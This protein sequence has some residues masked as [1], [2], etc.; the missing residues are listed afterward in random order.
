MKYSPNILFISHGIYLFTP[1]H[2]VI[3]LSQCLEVVNECRFG[4]IISPKRHSLLSPL[5]FD[6][7]SKI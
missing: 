5:C 3:I 1:S 4:L 2:N 6:N 7:Q